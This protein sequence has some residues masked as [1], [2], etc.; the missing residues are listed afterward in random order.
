MSNKTM[1]VREY[2]SWYVSLGLSVIPVKADGSK[3]PSYSGW[4]KYT[5]EIASESQLDEWFNSA[6]SGIGIVPGPAS[7]NLVILDFEYHNTSAYEDWLTKLPDDLREAVADMPTAITPSGGR[8]IY[9]RLPGSQ[10]GAKLARYASGKTKI[11]IRGEGHQVLTPGCPVECHKSGKLYEWM[12]PF[13]DIHVLDEDVW[14]QLCTFCSECNEYLSPEQP[15][16]NYS[17]SKGEPSGE[18]SPG[19]DFNRRGTWA[20]T[21]LFELGWHWQSQESGDVGYLTRPG[22]EVGISASV[23][24]VTS[25]EHGYPYF[26]CFSTSV[27]DFAP[28]TPYSRFA[29]YATLRHGGDYTAAAKELATVGYGESKEVFEA[30]KQNRYGVD[31]SGFALKQP[32]ANGEKVFPFA[33]KPMAAKSNDE[34]RHFKWMSELSTE[35][36]NAQWIWHGY[37]ARGGI[38]LFS[39]LWKAGKSTLLSHLLK[40]LDGSTCEFLG[41]AVAPSR[42]LYVT[43]EN[44]NIWATRR[45][46]LLIGDHVGLWVKPFKGRS[47]MLEWKQHLNQIIEDV[48]KY[49]FDLVIFDTLSKMWPVREEN[50]A[51][52]VEEALMP[53]WTLT[54]ENIAVM[55][56]HH[57]RK[58]G[59]EQFVGARGSGGLPAFCE[60][61]VEFSRTTPDPKETQRVLTA[62]GRYEETKVKWL[63]DLQQNSYVSL[64]DPDN[65]QVR[66]QHKDLGWKSTVL[67]ILKEQGETWIT[68]KDLLDKI[69]EREGKGVRDADLKVYLDWI[70]ENGEAERIGGGLKGNPHKYRLPQLD[71]HSNEDQESDEN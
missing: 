26:Y 48:K 25:K 1:T 29:V 71:S 27:N 3:S 69:K 20:E 34:K 23:G 61:L 22:K 39:A 28:E 67:D 47:T 9:I 11:E 42:V 8:H 46:K 4:R 10:P 37:L 64:G 30:K 6:L 49:Q 2:A 54:N 62:M 70:V 38:T 13:D 44:E 60:I 33:A 15:R 19:N 31:L 35:S 32:N 51:S 52:Q 50:D 66:A 45:D 59:G 14:V 41:L 21:G 65:A 12:K 40:A 56:V 17:S 57:S 68:K 18:G 53:L 63:I 58:S 55:L 5:S 7:G 36:D 24:K 16:D 43:E